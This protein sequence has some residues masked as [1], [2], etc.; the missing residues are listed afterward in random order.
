MLLLLCGA[1][2]VDSR[3]FSVIQHLLSQL[4]K[5]TAFSKNSKLFELASCSLIFAHLSYQVLQ[6]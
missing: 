4:I 2:W 6:S 5:L 3:S 1:K